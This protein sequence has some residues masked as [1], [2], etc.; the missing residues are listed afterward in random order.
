[1][2]EVGIVV[3]IHTD[4]I[5]PEKIEELYPY[6]EEM[7]DKFFKM[8]KEKWGPG[9]YGLGSDMATAYYTLPRI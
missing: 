2:I 3:G 8:S 7:P 5:D 4:A 9:D 6:L 1:M